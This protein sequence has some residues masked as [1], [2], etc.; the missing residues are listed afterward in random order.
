[1]RTSDPDIYAVGDVVEVENL[2]TGQPC[3]IPLAGPAN[4]QGRVAAD[5]V[6]G[7]GS[8]FDGVQGSAVLKVFD[9]TAAS[10][11]LNEKQL[12]FDK[13][14]YAKTYIHPLDH[15]DYY[16]GATQMAMKLLFDPEDGKILGAQA[17][18][19]QGVEKRIDVI[20]TAQRLGATVMDL[21]KLE[22]TYA[23]PY[24]SA[25]DPVNMLG[26]TAVNMMRGDVAV[27]HY[28]D[29]ADLDPNRDLLVD[30]G[31][32]RSLCRAVSPVRSIS[33]S[34]SFA[35]V[36][37]SCRKIAGFIY[38]AESAGAVI[39]LPESLSRTVSPRF[40]VSVAVMNYIT[41]WFSTKQPRTLVCL[42][43]NNNEDNISWRRRSGSGSCF[44]SKRITPDS[45]WIVVFIRDLGR[46]TGSIARFPFDIDHIDF[47]LLTHAHIDQRPHSK[48]Y[49][50]GYRKPIYMTKPQ[51][52]FA[53]SC[54]GLGYIQEMEAEWRNRKNNRAGRRKKMRF[55]QWTMP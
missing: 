37:M 43:R 20:A 19:F 25:K 29:V 35:T 22:L 13:I 11:G 32:K 34:K 6:S 26:F 49:V 50:D 14:R 8:T 39:S 36:L 27:F 53:A 15:A 3:L 41:R 16:P 5:H 44:W 47:M 40:L 1:M 52:N 42:R 24:S 18:G 45:W 4:K 7:R 28:H 12:K 9:M 38:S 31:P 17:V 10:T 33:H 55:I 30:V 23:P 2:V 51:P 48:L 54:C 46:R 21:E